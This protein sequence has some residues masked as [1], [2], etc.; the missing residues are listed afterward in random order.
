MMNWKPRVRSDSAS[1]RQRERIETRIASG[2]HHEAL[3]NAV[4]RQHAGGIGADAEQARLPERDQPGVAEQQIDAERGHAVD[5][6]L[7]REAHVV[8]AEIRR[9]RDRDGEQA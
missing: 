3:V 6:D 8:D 7:R 9:Q 5:R 1:D 4:D 2:Q